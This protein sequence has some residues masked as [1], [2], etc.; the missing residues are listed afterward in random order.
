MKSG[1]SGAG[2]CGRSGGRSVYW[3]DGRAMAV[4]MVVI[5]VAVKSLPFHPFYHQQEHTTY[6]RQ[7]EGD[8]GRR[9]KGGGGRRGEGVG[10]GRGG[11][12]VGQHHSNSPSSPPSE[13][14]DVAALENFMGRCCRRPTRSGCLAC[15]LV[16]DTVSAAPH[17][18]ARIL[19]HR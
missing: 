13:S 18:Q 9:R 19:E 12:S 15:S 11:G 5:E 4:V 8:R 3:W 14:P 7:Q 10:T 1:G 17:G 2:S 6:S 16:L